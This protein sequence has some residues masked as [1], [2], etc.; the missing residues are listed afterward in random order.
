MI[1]IFSTSE[2]P[3]SLFLA[4]DDYI[5]TTSKIFYGSSSFEYTFQPGT[6]VDNLIRRWPNE[7]DDQ[8]ARQDWGWKPKYDFSATIEALSNATHE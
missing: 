1:E 6:S 5:L 2:P 8:A 7:F 4:L 3:L